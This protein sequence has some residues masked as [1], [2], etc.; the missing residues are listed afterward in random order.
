M[1]ELVGKNLFVKALFSKEVR[2]ILIMLL[3]ELAK[4]TD[5]EI[6]DQV[7]GFIKSHFFDND[8]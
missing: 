4:R 8:C 5:N 3:E 7:I 2:N 1:F 6:D